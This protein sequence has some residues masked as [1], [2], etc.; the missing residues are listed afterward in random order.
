MPSLAPSLAPS[1]T[2]PAVANVLMVRARPTAVAGMPRSFTIPLIDTLKALNDSWTC[3][4]ITMISGNHDA[5]GADAVSWVVPEVWDMD[6]GCPTA[7]GRQ[8]LWACAA[9][10]RRPSADLV[11]W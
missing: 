1:S 5:L 8:M 9:Q 7:G 3:A 10:W 2:N 11:D 4:I 6:S